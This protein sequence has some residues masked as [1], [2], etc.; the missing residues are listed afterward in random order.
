[1]IRH[2]PLRNV[3]AVSP[4]SKRDEKFAP[5]PRSVLLVPHRPPTATTPLSTGKLGNVLFPLIVQ[6]TTVYVL[7][8][9]VHACDQHG[10][11]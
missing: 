8:L 9:T 6:D 3:P 7:I 4:L 5:P 11:S 2:S 1:M 10:P